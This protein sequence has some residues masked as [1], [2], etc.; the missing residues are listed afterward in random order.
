MAQGIKIT[1]TKFHDKKQYIF[2]VI[3]TDATLRYDV[4]HREF[5]V[6]VAG[7]IT[8]RFNMEMTF[9]DF[10]IECKYQFK[11]IVEKSFGLN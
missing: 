10:E 1:P 7:F 2:H 8:R 11:K 5:Q 6:V 9:V 3:G 4:I